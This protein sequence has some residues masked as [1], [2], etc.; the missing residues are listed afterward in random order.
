M[1][2]AGMALI[3]LDRKNVVKI[4]G[5]PSKNLVKLRWLLAAQNL[6]PTEER[7]SQLMCCFIQLVLSDPDFVSAVLFLYP[8]STK[9]K[10]GDIELPFVPL[11]VHTGRIPYKVLV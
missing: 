2:C 11:S 6:V 5:L 9:L 7:L 1:C 3:V 10:K 8:V 4:L